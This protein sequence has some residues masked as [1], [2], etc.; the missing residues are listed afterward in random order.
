MSTTTGDANIVQVDVEQVERDALRFV[1]SVE[2][3]V[4]LEELCAHLQVT[5][6]PTALGKTNSVLKIILFHLNSPTLAQADD[7][8]LSVF[9]ATRDFL[10]PLL[11]P[12]DVDDGN[13]GDP[14]ANIPDLSASSEEN[15][16]TDNADVKTEPI[17]ETPYWSLLVPMVHLEVPILR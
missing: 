16:D 17:C 10:A 5:V 11:V 8:G 15:S 9:T 2:D 4:V 1:T 3:S 14:N 13:V 12:D 6:P 7:G